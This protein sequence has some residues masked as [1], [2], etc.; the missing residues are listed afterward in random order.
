[1]ETLKHVVVAVRSRAEGSRILFCFN[2]DNEPFALSN[3]VE[4]AILDQR[5]AKYYHP[6][7][8]QIV[9]FGSVLVPRRMKEG[10]FVFSVDT[11]TLVVYLK[12]FPEDEDEEKFVY[13][14]EL[15]SISTVFLLQKDVYIRSVIDGFMTVSKTISKALILEEINSGYVSTQVRKIFSTRQKFCQE[16]IRRDVPLTYKELVTEIIT[17]SDLASAMQKIFID[18][19][20]NGVAH[21]KMNKKYLPPI[22]LKNYDDVFSQQLLPYHSIFLFKTSKEWIS[23]LTNSD[24]LILLPE[25]F[26]HIQ[27][28]GF[29]EKVKKVLQVSTPQTSLQYLSM[30]TEIPLLEIYDVVRYLVYWGKAKVIEAVF[31]DDVYILS[32]SKET[33]PGYFLPK[34]CCESPQ[35]IQDGT[36]SHI[37]VKTLA[38][39]FK[40]ECGG[41]ITKVLNSFIEKKTLDKILEPIPE[42]D[43]DSFVEAFTWLIAHDVLIRVRKYLYCIDKKW[44]NDLQLHEESTLDDDLKQFKKME[45]YFDGKTDLKEISS[46]TGIT[47]PEIFHLQKKYQQ[48]VLMLCYE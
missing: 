46:K 3:S 39:R 28:K 47:L 21:T 25:Q 35:K 22:S 20:T 23:C 31:L 27:N 13:F 4:Q 29:F 1:M 19:K 36:S 44:F 8:A 15:T 42:G 43:Q 9:N 33:Q 11:Y 5:N 40:E 10:P 17:K 18:L 38:M 32:P 16:N 14:F 30:T 34:E 2:M 45:M 12:E 48:Y 41:D 7:E 37:K 24:D 26:P 6:S